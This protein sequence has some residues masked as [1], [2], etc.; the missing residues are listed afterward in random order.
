MVLSIAERLITHSPL[1]CQHRYTVLRAKLI[2]GGEKRVGQ[3]IVGA[4]HFGRTE[5]LVAGASVKD[6]RTH[7]AIILRW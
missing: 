7:Q 5:L 1:L 3:E 2:Y 6:I 4:S